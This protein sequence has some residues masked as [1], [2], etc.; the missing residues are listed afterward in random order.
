[1]NEFK[2][3]NKL[4]A[5]YQIAGGFIGI[6]FMSY[7]LIMI[8]NLQSRELLVSTV[9]LIL[10]VFSIYSGN[11]LIGK[12]YS[13]GLAYSKVNQLIQILGFKISGL[14]Y[15]FGSGLIMCV[16]F[17]LTDDFITGFIFWTSYFEIGQL[18]D[19]SQF[20]I[21]FNIIAI[22]LLFQVGKLRKQYESLKDR[23]I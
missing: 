6:V 17:D 5:I 15:V 19:R 12:H 9:P 13:K 11:L 2:K 7:T 10:F 8:E 14:M 20:M 18:A 4:L 16:Q 21:S 22:F 1:M 3:R 23:L